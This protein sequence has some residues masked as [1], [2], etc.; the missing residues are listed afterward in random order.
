MNDL[1]KKLLSVIDLNK[2]SVIVI[3]D[4]ILGSLKKV[5]EDSSNSFDDAAFA[6]V[7]PLVKAEAEKYLAELIAKI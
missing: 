7:A 3:E 5:V 1:E 2:L 6:M 4:V